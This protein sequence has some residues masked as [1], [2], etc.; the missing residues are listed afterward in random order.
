MLIDTN[1]TEY[2]AAPVDVGGK[3]DQDVVLVVG[4]TRLFLDYES[5]CQLTYALT[6]AI[7]RRWR[8]D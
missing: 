4:E 6:E 5:V 3:H 8:D 2:Y 1:G 7:T